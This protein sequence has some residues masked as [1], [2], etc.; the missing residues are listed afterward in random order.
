MTIDELIEALQRAKEQAGSG[1]CPVKFDDLRGAV[2]KVE[3]V[4]VRMSSVP[5][6]VVLSR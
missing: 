3:T 5:R 6:Y 4:K 2:E 1:N